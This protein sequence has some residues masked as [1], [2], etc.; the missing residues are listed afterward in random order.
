MVG[1]YKCLDFLISVLCQPCKEKLSDANH[2][3]PVMNNLLIQNQ[4]PGMIL[5]ANLQLCCL[6]FPIYL[7][8]LFTHF[9][10]LHVLYGSVG[11]G[12]ALPL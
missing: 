9:Q 8:L 5:S 7:H 1:T 11:G 6:E 3:R 2:L 12:L 4:G 10:R